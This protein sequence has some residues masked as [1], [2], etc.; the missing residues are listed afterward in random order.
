MALG[1]DEASKIDFSRLCAL[2]PHYPTAPYV[3]S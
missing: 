1:I 3:L 2:D